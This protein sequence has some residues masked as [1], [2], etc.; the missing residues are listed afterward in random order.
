MALRPRP[1]GRVAIE[2]LRLAPVISATASRALGLQ[3][4]RRTNVQAC[5]EAGPRGPPRTNLQ[6][7]PRT[8]YQLPDAGQAP[9]LVVVQERVIAPAA[10][11]VIVKLLPDFE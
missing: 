2:H 4:A 9:L 6:V 11:L 5:D 10:A 1:H 7:Y 3:D 8:D